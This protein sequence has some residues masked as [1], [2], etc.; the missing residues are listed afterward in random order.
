M[1]IRKGVLGPSVVFGGL[2]VVVLAGCAGKSNRAGGEGP[3]E[4]STGYGTQPRELTTSAVSSYE[5]SRSE[6]EA[7]TLEQLLAKVSGLEVIRETG[8]YRLRIRGVR[9]LNA[10]NSDP[11]IVI[12]GRAVG[13]GLLNIPPQDIAKIDVLKDA[14]ATA[15][16]GMRGANGVVVIT[17]KRASAR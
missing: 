1:K 15:L 7:A 3:P 9:S 16:Y 10:A 6:G 2:A 4:V 13:Y 11:L 14:G 5:P 8:G 12:D 17:T